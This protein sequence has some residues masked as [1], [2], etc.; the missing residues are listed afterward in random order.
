MD[1]TASKGHIEIVKWLHEN[2]KEGCTTRAMYWAE[3]MGHLE[4][5]KWLK[6]NI[7]N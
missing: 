2:R 7:K 6:D 1:L 4:I 3:R 5:V